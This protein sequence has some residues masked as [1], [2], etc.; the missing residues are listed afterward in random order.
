MFRLSSSIESPLNN[1]NTNVVGVGTKYLSELTPGEQI[2][3][4]ADDFETIAS[5]QTDLTAQ[6]TANA[7]NN[8]GNAQV[9]RVE[10]NDTA[11]SNANERLYQPPL[12]V[13]KQGKALPPARY[14][15][16]LRPKPDLVY[17]QSAL[18]SQG[19]NLTLLSGANEGALNNGTSE[20]LVDDI[21]FYIAVVDNY[22]RVAD[23]MSYVLDLEETE[24][25]PRQIN[26]A[27][28]T[29]NFT[30][31]K[32]TFGL[33]VALQDNRAGRNTLFPPSIFKVQGDS[34]QELTSLRIDYAGRL[35]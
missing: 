31:S 30:V 15:L 19:G 21:V 5:V 27:S 23:Q 4:A 7:Q 24:V 3:T 14:E 26:G 11:Q 22:E 29:E 20:Y 8:V 17:K 12:G 1:A 6:L 2:Q 13:F 18:Q 16:I 33:S 10:N 34:Q 35:A 32:S 9:F 25:L 28:I